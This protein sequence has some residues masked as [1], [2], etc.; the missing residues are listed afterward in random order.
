MTDGGNEDSGQPS[1][2]DGKVTRSLVCGTS[3]GG[4]ISPDGAHAATI[5]R[6]SGGVVV[7]LDGKAGPTFLNVTDGV[8]V[9]QPGQQAPGIRGRSERRLCDVHRR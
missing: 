5:K 7:E 6:V 8:S 2:L 4:A 1:I 3:S 9:I